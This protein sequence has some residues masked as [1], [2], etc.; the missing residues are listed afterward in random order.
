MAIEA[1]IMML[2]PYPEHRWLPAREA[3]APAILHEVECAI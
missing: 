1:G 2:R 3:A